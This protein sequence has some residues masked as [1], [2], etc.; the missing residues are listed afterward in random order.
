MR[1]SPRWRSRSLRARLRPARDPAVAEQRLQRRHRR[2][3]RRGAVEDEI[4]V[5]RR[6]VGVVDARQPAQVP[7]ARAPVEALGVALLADLERGLDVDLDERQPFLGVAAA[8][9]I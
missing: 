6:L 2:F 7:G 3:Q 9:A 5:W 4:G 1:I 8:Y